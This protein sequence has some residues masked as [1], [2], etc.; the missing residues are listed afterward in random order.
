MKFLVGVV[1]D[2][3]H[4]GNFKQAKSDEKHKNLTTREAFDEC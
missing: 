4:L 3:P 2:I 1:P